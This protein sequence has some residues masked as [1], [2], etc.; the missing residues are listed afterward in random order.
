VTRIN[1]F[2]VD[3]EEWYQGLTS[4][5]RHPERWESLE[6]RSVEA[7]ETVLALLRAGG[8]RATF[9]VL[10]ALAERQPVRRR[11]SGM[12]GTRSRCTA[13]CTGGWMA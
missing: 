4:A 12:P 7:T 11:A 13:T 2:T 8:V 3:L 9:F 1:A 6:S 5:N 10:G